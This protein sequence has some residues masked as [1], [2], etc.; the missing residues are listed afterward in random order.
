MP[1]VQLLNSK[2]ITFSFICRLRTSNAD[3]YGIWNETLPNS[4]HI[5]TLVLAQLA[6]FITLS[7]LYGCVYVSVCKYNTHLIHAVAVSMFS[8]MYVRIKRELAKEW[9]RER[10]RERERC[11]NI[12]CGGKRKEKKRRRMAPKKTAIHTKVYSTSSFSSMACSKP[13]AMAL[14]LPPGLPV[15]PHQHSFSRF[16]SFS[17][18]FSRWKLLWHSF[19]PW[20]STHLLSLLLNGRKPIIY[21]TCYEPAAEETSLPPDAIWI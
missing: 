19:L 12:H 5:I 15:P 6:G 17:L 18:S 21:F 14:L 20:S 1:H 2:P 9:E 11:I 13:A 16:L 8:V 10:E 3:S 4:L 7:C